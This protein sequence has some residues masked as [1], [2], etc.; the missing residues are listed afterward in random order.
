MAWRCAFNKPED[1]LALIAASYVPVVLL[2]VS[3]KR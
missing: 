1:F 3:M 2:D